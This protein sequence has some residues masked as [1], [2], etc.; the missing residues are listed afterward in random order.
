MNLGVPDREDQIL[1][2]H[3]HACTHARTHAHTHTHT[4]TRHY[5]TTVKINI[6]FQRNHFL[7]CFQNLDQSSL[8]RCW[9]DF[10]RGTS[11]RISTHFI[12]SSPCQCVT[13]PP[14][15]CFKTFINTNRPGA[16]GECCEIQQEY[17]RR[18]RGKKKQKTEKDT[19]STDLQY[20]AEYSDTL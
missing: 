5:C 15:G 2:T 12:S 9:V 20:T 13:L 19:V 18:K 11:H 14:S 4:H 10:K 16:H 6:Y 7:K 8:L 3:T 1:Y 17:S